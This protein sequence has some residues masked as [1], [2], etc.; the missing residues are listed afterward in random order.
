MIVANNPDRAVTV[1][2]RDPIT[3][4]DMLGSLRRPSNRPHATGFVGTGI[5]MPVLLLRSHGSV[6]GDSCMIF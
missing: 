3:D 6:Y 4:R 1:R 2:E 5:G